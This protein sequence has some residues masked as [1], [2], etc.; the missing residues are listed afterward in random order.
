MVKTQAIAS[1]DWLKFVLKFVLSIMITCNGD[2]KCDESVVYTYLHTLGHIHSCILACPNMDG[3]LL[4]MYEY[5][6]IVY[7]S[8]INIVVQ[9]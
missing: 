8:H 3:V 4:Y 6:L 9:I 5:Q 2:I 7:T 1:F